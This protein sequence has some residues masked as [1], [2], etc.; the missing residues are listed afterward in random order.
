MVFK[1]TRVNSFDRSG[2][3]RIRTIHQYHKKKYLFGI[4][5]TYIK[6]AVETLLRFPPRIRGKRFRP[7]R[8]GFIVRGF[9]S[10]TKK[11]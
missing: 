2:P 7:I 9:L 4:S 10:C 8:P 6:G 11:C 3:S 1:E 5:G